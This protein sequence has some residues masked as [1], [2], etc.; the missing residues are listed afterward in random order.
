VLAGSEE[1]LQARFAGKVE[2][3]MTVI[4]TLLAGLFDYAGLYPPASL[5]L[6]SA[7]ENYL[8]YGRSKHAYALGRFIINFDHLN[9]LRAIA[10]SSLDSFKLSVIAAE[11]TDWKSLSKQIEAGLPVESV[12]IKC[13]RPSAIE[14]IAR[15]IPG[16]LATYFEVP[17]IADIEPALKAIH[18]TGA[19]AKIRMGG[20][21]PEAFPTVSDVVRMLKSLADFRLPFKAT[22]GL[23]HPIRSIHPLTYGPQGPTGIMH[24]FVNLCCAAGILYFGGDV[25]EA[26]HLLAEE[27]SAAWKVNADSVRWRERS[28]STEQ[29]ATLR[30]QFFISIGSCSFEEP[31]HDLESLGWL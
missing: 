29:L 16:T 7:A 14:H 4:K 9:E 31:I 28:W 2:E 12:E 5:N 6:R 27:N 13:S 3:E 21:V 19:R 26:Q 8:E 1:T 15:Q 25:D 17:F 10:G 20:V 24:G 23:H 11:D 18:A 22:A 30:S